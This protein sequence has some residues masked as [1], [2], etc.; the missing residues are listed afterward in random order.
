MLRDN[1]IGLIVPLR[2]SGTRASDDRSPCLENPR[3]TGA[4]TSLAENVTSPFQ[5]EPAQL[6]A[7]MSLSAIYANLG[8]REEAL[9]ESELVLRQEPD[10]AVH[11]ATLAYRY[12][13]LDRMDEAKAT[14][15]DAS[16]RGLE[17]NHLHWT[18]Y[19]LAFLSHDKK[20]MEEQLS[21]SKGK[22]GAESLVNAWQSST[23]CYY[24]RLQRA[25]EYARRF[26]DSAKRKGD[27]GSAA[28]YLAVIASAEVDFGETQRA[29]NDASEALA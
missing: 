25:R 14:L 2:S 7:H 1:L 28:I 9:R 27:K 4:E 8:L 19:R 16:K 20:A 3:P 5:A 23:E 13:L 21:W 17:S 18:Q 29:I 12:S 22:P 6:T 11:Y 26:V 10:T 24:G 15:D